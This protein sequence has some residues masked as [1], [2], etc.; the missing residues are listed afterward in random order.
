M[1]YMTITATELK[2]NL[3]KYLNIASFQS[4][5]ITKNGSEVATLTSPKLKEKKIEALN[6]ITGIIREK[7]L[8]LND[9]KVNRI[10]HR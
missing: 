4:I 9:D 10:I 5:T 6:S 2:N 7:D 1:R 8:D 3:G